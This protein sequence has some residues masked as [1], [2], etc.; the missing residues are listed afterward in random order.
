[1]KSCIN[2]INYK[3]GVIPCSSLTLRSLALAVSG[4][5]KDSSWVPFHDCFLLWVL[6]F[7]IGVDV[8]A[9]ASPLIAIIL[10]LA[11]LIFSPLVASQLLLI[12]LKV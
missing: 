8:F 6:V 3:A 12:A 7:I 1:M 5:L 9:G 4:T 11:T 10:V 2:F